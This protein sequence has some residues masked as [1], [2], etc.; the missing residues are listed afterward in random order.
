MLSC[1]SGRRNT[2]DSFGVSVANILKN[3]VR[4]VELMDEAEVILEAF[5]LILTDTCRN[6]VGVCT[7]QDTVVV[8]NEE[9]VIRLA[10][11]FFEVIAPAEEEA[12]RRVDIKLREFVEQLSESVKTEVHLMRTD[13]RNVRV[14]AHEI[15]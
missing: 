9:I 12:Y 14:T 11:T 2:E 3:V 1:G 5:E 7:E 15:L 8:L 6:D 13:D 4:Q 10:V